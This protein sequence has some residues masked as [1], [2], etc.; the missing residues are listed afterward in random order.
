[1]DR[2]V[3]NCGSVSILVIICCRRITNRLSA[4]RMRKKHA[5][6]RN[7]TQTAVSFLPLWLSGSL[8]CIL[9]MSNVQLLSTPPPRKNHALQSFVKLTLRPIFCFLQQQIIR[10]RK[11]MCSGKPK[12]SDEAFV[13]SSF[14]LLMGESLMTFAAV[15]IR[16]L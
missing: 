10:F 6:E 12:E 11:C 13:L 8:S 14:K 7:V 5:E 3:I 16:L 9:S 1:M 15:R 2:H 4:R